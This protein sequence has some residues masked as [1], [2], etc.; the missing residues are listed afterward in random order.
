M[1][2]PEGTDTDDLSVYLHNQIKR[3]SLKKLMPDTVIDVVHYDRTTRQLTYSFTELPRAW[4]YTRVASLEALGKKKKNYTLASA[5]SRHVVAG[6]QLIADTDGPTPQV[7]LIRE[8]TQGVVDTGLNPQGIVNTQYRLQVDWDDPSGVAESW[9][10]T[11]TGT[12]LAQHSGS[13]VA[14]TNLYLEEPQQL[15]YRIGA[16]DSS[17]NTAHETVLLVIAVP[18]LVIDDIVKS[19]STHNAFTILSSISKGMDAGQVQFERKRNNVWTTLTN[20]TMTGSQTFA[21]PL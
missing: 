15:Y 20:P 4:Y 12:I 16:R 3:S 2:V 8:R 1:F 13:S 5:W 7:R 10:S 19:A 21:Y 18:T 17:N 11:E 6:Q 9:I 14:L